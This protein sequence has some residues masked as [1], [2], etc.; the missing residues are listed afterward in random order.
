MAWRCSV[1]TATRSLA[2][3]IKVLTCAL[4][5]ERMPLIS[6]TLLEQLAQCLVAAVESSRQ[7][8]DPV[9]GRAQLRGNRIDG[10]RQCAEG[11]VEGL[12]VGARDVGREV[13]D[14]LGD[15]IGRGGA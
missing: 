12:G 15:R 3:R 13:T 14:R 7:P 2:F 4:R 6:R 5:A 8:S 10:R 9:E 1:S 11:L